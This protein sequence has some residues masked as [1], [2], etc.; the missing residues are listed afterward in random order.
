V[1]AKLDADARTPRRATASDLAISLI[2]MLTP[3][4]RHH[5]AGASCMPLR[6]IHVRLN[7]AVLLSWLC[8][9]LSPATASETVAAIISGLPG[10]PCKQTV[11]G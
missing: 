1:A 11:D 3:K 10:L 4:S 9:F 2:I 5:V 8:N 6:W 7:S